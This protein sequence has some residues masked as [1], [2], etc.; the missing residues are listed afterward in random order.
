MKLG[1]V[2]LAALLASSIQR[3]SGRMAK[4]PASK[5]AVKASKM[6]LVN[7][8]IGYGRDVLKIS[9]AE[10]ELTRGRANQMSLM[11]RMVLRHSVPETGWG[12]N[13]AEWSDLF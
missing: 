11:E 2:A 13:L 6:F 5:A 10:N 4:S 12:Q 3:L 7:A 9:H 1:W 8:R